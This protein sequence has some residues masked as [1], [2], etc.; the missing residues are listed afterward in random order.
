MKKFVCF[1]LSMALM[2]GCFNLSAYAEETTYP[3]VL[4]TYTSTEDYA[5]DEWSTAQRGAYLLSGTSCIA[6]ES[7]TQ[8]NISGD[9]TAT[10]VCDKIVLTLYVERSKSYATG[11]STYK[12]YIYTAQNA[13]QL[14]KEISYITVERGYYYRVYGVHSVT[15]NGTTETTNSVTNPISYI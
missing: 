15:H 1:V 7:S 8:I 5:S 4:H 14:A 12:S 11:Y 3:M 10:Q 9:T 6:R 2:M 13:Y